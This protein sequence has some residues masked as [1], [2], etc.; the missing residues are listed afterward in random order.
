MDIFSQCAGL[1]RET[2]AGSRYGAIVRRR[3]DVGLQM[4]LWLQARAAGE[5]G[6][7]MATS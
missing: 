5:A 3:G 2:K 4:H 6:V 1:R 7:T